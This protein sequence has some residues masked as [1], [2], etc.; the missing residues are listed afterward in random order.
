[1]FKVGDLVFPKHFRLL[2]LIL[3]GK[4]GDDKRH[5]FGDFIDL[6]TNFKIILFK[7]VL[8]GLPL[9]ANKL[10][11]FVFNQYG[12]FTGIIP[13]KLIFI[14]TRIDVIGKPLR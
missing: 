5:V 2:N 12:F 14:R 8:I 13:K 10:I 9:I 6:N 11:R 4:I 3:I 7:I 1:M